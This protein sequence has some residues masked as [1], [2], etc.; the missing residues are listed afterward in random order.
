MRYKDPVLRRVIQDLS[1]FVA[2][3]G[4]TARRARVCLGAILL[5]VRKDK[6]GRD[7]L[8]HIR[9]VLQAILS[10]GVT[11]EQEHIP[12]GSEKQ[13]AFSTDRLWCERR[14]TTPRH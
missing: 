13:L 14:E 3:C 8:L 5:P 7:D 12:T 1:V 6:N 10:A 9:N 2:I 4:T 11:D